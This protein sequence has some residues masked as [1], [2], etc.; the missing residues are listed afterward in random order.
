MQGNLNT[1]EKENLQDIFK[2]SAGRSLIELYVLLSSAFCCPVSSKTNNWSSY[3]ITTLYSWHIY[4]EKINAPFLTALNKI[5]R[6]LNHLKCI[7][8]FGEFFQHLPIFQFL[9]LKQKKQ[10][11][12]TD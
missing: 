4:T 11:V 6:N 10:Q 8:F 3:F 1:S 5:K 7:F 2:N 12:R 9:L